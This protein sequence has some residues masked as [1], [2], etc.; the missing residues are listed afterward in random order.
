MHSLT[1]IDP[2]EIYHSSSVIPNSIFEG[3]YSFIAIALEAQQ[4]YSAAHLSVFCYNHFLN[5]TK[6]I[7]IM[8]PTH[9]LFVLTYIIPQPI[10]V[11]RVTIAMIIIQWVIIAMM[12]IVAI[13]VLALI[14]TTFIITPRVIK[15]RASMKAF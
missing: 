13:R 14:T 10:I 3:T 6:D 1:F 12:I 2:I 7:G 8:G 11:H 4:F 9:F 5:T 15:R